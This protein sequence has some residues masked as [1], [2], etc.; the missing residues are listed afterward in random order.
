[1]VI[2]FTKRISVDSN[3]MIKEIRFVVRA[4]FDPFLPTYSSGSASRKQ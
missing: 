2:S 4:D 3:M 1:M